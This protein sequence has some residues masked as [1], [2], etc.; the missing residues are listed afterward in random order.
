MILADIH[1]VERPREKLARS[2][3]EALS[4]QELLA[5]ILRTG[6]AGRNVLELA[7]SVLQAHPEGLGRADYRSLAG[8]KG[9]GESRAAS[10][11]AALELGRR[12]SGSRDLRPVLDRPER[13]LEQ[14]PA[15]VRSGRKEHL[16]AF[17]LNARSQML[18]SE[19]VSVGT[20]SASLVHPREVFAPAIACSAAALVVL[21]NH[22]SGDSTPSPEDRDATRR[23]LRCGELL[24]IPLLDHLIVAEGGFFSFKEQGL[25]G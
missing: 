20:L 21:H 10:L 8:L 2:S 22:P 6:Y 1:P 11:V 23:L 3:P 4:D 17:Y 14:T 7:G 19:T 9:M 12:W 5:L 24:G 25:L 18:H 13:V 16:L 15:S